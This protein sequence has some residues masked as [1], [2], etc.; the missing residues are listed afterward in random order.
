MMC[1]TLVAI[2]KTIIIDACN[3]KLSGHIAAVQ[4]NR[5]NCPG[6]S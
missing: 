3:I 5:Y 4:Y 6:Y 1:H 2:H